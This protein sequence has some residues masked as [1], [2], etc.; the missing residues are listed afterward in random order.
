MPT[1]LDVIGAAGDLKSLSGKV[2]QDTYSRFIAACAHL[3]VNKNKAVAAAI[4]QAL[5][6]LED[7]MKKRPAKEK[8]AKKVKADASDVFAAK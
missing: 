2:S 8:K 7:E 3:G 1:L 5:P 4:S 6:M